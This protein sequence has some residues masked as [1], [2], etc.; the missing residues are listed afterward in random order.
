[1]DALFDGDSG[2]K[3]FLLECLVELVEKVIACCRELTQFVLSLGTLLI[4]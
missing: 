2:R 1:M 4:D 3:N